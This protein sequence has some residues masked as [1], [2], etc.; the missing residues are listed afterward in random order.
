MDPGGAE[1]QLLYVL[2]NLQFVNINKVTLFVISDRVK[3][4][5]E[6]ENKNVDVI[7]VGANSWKDLF[8]IFS[9]FK[10]IRDF[11]PTI[12][13]T[14]MYTS[15]LL[16]RLYKVL[17]HRQVKLVNHVHG[18]GLWLPKTRILLDRVTHGIADKILFVSEKSRKL[19]ISREKL[20]PSKLDVIYNA[21]D[22][23]K[24]AAA[25][26]PVQTPFIFG[27]AARLIPL[28]RVELAIEII[29]NLNV[30]GFEC[31][32]FI[33][34]DGP[35]MDKLSSLVNEQELIEKVKFLG[36][37]KDMPKF[38]QMIDGF[39]LTSSIEDF[40][41]SIIEALAAGKFVLAGDVGGVPEALLATS[42]F[43]ISDY[44]DSTMYSK[45]ISRINI[46]VEEGQEINMAKAKAR[47]DVLEQVK[48]LKKLYNEIYSSKENV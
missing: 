10:R 12:L 39:I 36:Y 23:T 19:R 18:L 24:F 9:L 21:V 31:K 25:K 17:Y 2:N 41:L 32:L 46:F 15:N 26:A 43:L 47:F 45:I 37:I 27:I 5:A 16:G 30:H 4:L 28:K 13:H 48:N 8:K 34:G 6:L 29:K 35:E 7:V 33:A 40:P 20:N 42:S 38:Y 22:A 3:L 1:K 14:Q 11:N 44:E